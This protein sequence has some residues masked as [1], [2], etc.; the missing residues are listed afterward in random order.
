MFYSN[1]DNLLK[2]NLTAAGNFKKHHVTATHENFKIINWDINVDYRMS[3]NHSIW[4]RE[5]FLSL[6]RP[7]ET[8]WQFETSTRANNENFFCL[9][10]K[11]T[12]ALCVGHGYKK[13]RKITNWYADSQKLYSDLNKE[14]MD[15]IEQ[16]NWVPEL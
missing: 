4:N 2:F 1:K 16:N 14:D 8:P 3:L 15:F 12:Y 5:L 13:G 9:G 10:T 11:D 6:L 7:N